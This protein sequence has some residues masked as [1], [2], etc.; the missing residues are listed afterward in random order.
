[1]NLSLYLLIASVV[2]PC[3][4]AFTAGYLSATLVSTYDENLPIAIY[5]AFSSY[6]I[7]SKFS[8]SSHSDLRIIEWNKYLS[9]LDADDAAE[10]NSN[11]DAQNNLTK[12]AKRLSSG[13]QQILVDL[14]Y[15]DTVF[16]D[17]EKAVVSKFLTFVK[18]MGIDAFTYECHRALPNEGVRCMGYAGT[19]TISLYTWPK[20]G[21]LSLNVLCNLNDPWSSVVP[22]ANEVFGASMTSNKPS[23]LWSL[24]QRNTS[25]LT[26]MAY[27]PSSSS[28]A[29]DTNSMGSV[30]A[31]FDIDGVH[32]KPASAPRSVVNDDVRQQHY[33]QIYSEALV[34]PVMFSHDNPKRVAII[35][36]GTGATLR[37]VLKHKTVEKVVIVG[38][39]A[40]SLQAFTKLY[41][42]H[43]DCSTLEGIAPYCY[44]DARVELISDETAL[45]WLLGDED[46]DSD[47]TA[48]YLFDVIVFEER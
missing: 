12:N 46:D 10:E 5:E 9:E 39:D 21:I 24:Q 47:N 25:K 6:F 38:A 43:S 17:S 4:L 14:Q 41:P 22:L 33:D 11:E 8:D 42:Q 13:S 37:E 48:D 27:S 1:M 20:L 15:L 44:D 3:L 18:K 45:E 34:H 26:W 40:E 16:L 35:G 31:S 32:F 2:G 19:E 36:K 29:D 30:E 23:S 7:P 28:M